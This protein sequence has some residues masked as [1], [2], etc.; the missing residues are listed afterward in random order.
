[1]FDRDLIEAV[2]EQ[3]A[4]ENRA[5]GD[6]VDALE[7]CLDRL[8]GEDRDLVRRRYELGATNRS[9]SKTVGRSESTISRA[10]NRIYMGLLSCLHA[11]T[12]VSAMTGGRP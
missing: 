9:V 1:M 6:Y 8:S 4:A 5:R 7:S 11:E 12:A 2:A 10:L 3:V